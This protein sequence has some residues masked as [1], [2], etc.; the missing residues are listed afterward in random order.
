MDSEMLTRFFMWGTILNAAFLMVAFMVW[1]CAADYMYRT[2]NRLFG[3]SR[4]SFNLV[5]YVFI[6]AYK[7]I[8]YAFFLTPWLALLI[9]S[10]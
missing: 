1:V 5:F 7:L 2:H 8:T 9:I 6:G 10:R 3:I 4:E